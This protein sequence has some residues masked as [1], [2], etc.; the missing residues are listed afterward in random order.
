ME[1]ANPDL[2]STPMWLLLTDEA[3]RVELVRRLCDAHGAAAERRHH[4]MDGV[5]RKAWAT[6]DRREL[7]RKVQAAM[8]EYSLAKNFNDTCSA[9]GLSPS[10]Q[11]DPGLQT[12]LSFLWE[13]L[14]EAGQGKA[15]G[16]D[17]YLSV[18][19]L[20]YQYLIPGISL[21]LARLVAEHAMPTDLP[22]KARGTPAGPTSMQKDGF[23]KFVLGIA[24]AW[25]EAPTVAEVQAVVA[26]LAQCL[27]GREAWARQFTVRPPTQEGT[28]RSEPATD[29]GEMI[30]A[31]MTEISWTT[32]LQETDRKT[33]S[34]SIR[35]KMG[36]Q[37][38]RAKKGA[39]NSALP[40]QTALS[41][42]NF[43][44]FSEPS[45]LSLVAPKL[46]AVRSASPD[47]AAA[48]ATLPLK[49]ADLRLLRAVPALPLHTADPAQAANPTRHI[50]PVYLDTLR[51]SKS[52]LRS[53]PPPPA[54]APVLPLRR[55]L[56]GS[57]T[58]RGPT[59]Y[60]LLVPPPPE[61]PQPPDSVVGPART[62]TRGSYVSLRK[63]L[64]SAAPSDWTVLEAM[65]SAYEMQEHE[66]VP[67]SHE[68]FPVDP[69]LE[70]FHKTG[71]WPKLPR[72]SS[73]TRRPQLA[74]GSLSA[75][76]PPAETE[77]VRFDC[78]TWTYTRTLDASSP[79]PRSLDGGDYVAVVL[80]KGFTPVNAPSV[81]C[82]HNVP[83]TAPSLAIEMRSQRDVSRKHAV[84]LWP[85]VDQRLQRTAS[86]PAVRAPSPAAGPAEHR[87]GVRPD[88][89]TILWNG[90][91]CEEKHRQ[92][93]VR[94]DED[95]NSSLGTLSPRL[96]PRSTPATARKK[97]PRDP[98]PFVE[99]AAPLRNIMLQSYDD[100]E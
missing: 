65:G 45:P 10:V 41:Y 68:V 19:V 59:P 1:S 81:P 77:K 62:E 93:R 48:T 54:L 78:H 58:R 52:R 14:L 50:T 60:D 98:L 61:G 71:Y 4:G 23:Q 17:L 15:M 47:P 80:K 75:K 89:A 18:S 11:E 96:T 99:D 57:P 76:V 27:L 53:T 66:L 8:V 46:A 64:S 24:G 36:S 2:S 13:Q 33:Q 90:L 38:R 51:P 92:H 86:P 29:I 28:A 63:H 82:G 42:H 95:R 100:D 6:L 5:V 69:R 94:H 37:S 40:T 3:V 30:V 55:K 26:C 20:L 91:R 34:T 67:A 35:K 56:S 12:D 87:P 39:A 21:R 79:Q 49:P 73:P 25:A 43:Q 32:T 44:R 7:F 84:V 97:S 22:Q 74:A 83:I 31:Q 16:E 70:F 72:T 88:M 85:T 9:G